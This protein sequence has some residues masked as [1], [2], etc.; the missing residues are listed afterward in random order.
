MDS[1]ETSIV[2]IS[3]DALNELF[4]ETPDKTVNADTLI[5]GKKDAKKAQQS[6]PPDNGDDDDEEDIEDDEVPAKKVD[7]NKTKKA[8]KVPTRQDHIETFTDEDLND[9]EEELEDDDEDK[10]P[11]DDEDEDKK[12]DKSK[13]GTKRAQ[14]AEDE[15]NDDENKGSDV[16]SILKSTVDYLVKQGVW[17]DFDGRE[18]MDIDEETYAKLVLEQDRHRVQ[19][20]FE[21][22]VDSTGPFG[23][24]IIDFV[25]NGGNPDEIIDLFKEQKQVE[26]INIENIDGQKDL[27]KHY[28]TDVMGWKP[29]KAE[30][31]ITSL[32]VSNELESEAQDVKEL[33]SNYYKK[34][35]ERLNQERADFARQQKEAEQAFENNIR[36]AVKERKDL[37]PSERRMVEDYLLN[38]DQRLPNGN[39]VN[40]FYV[41]F[42]KMQ[43]NPADYIDLVLFVMDKQKFVQKVATTEKSKA[44]AEAFK[45]IKGNSATSTKKGSGYEQIKK[46]EKVSGFDWGLPNNR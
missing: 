22:L 12:D 44:A 37:T 1:L 11:E 28:Y 45:F 9:D 39:T 16:S 42:A 23:K 30:K 3:E 17:D 4:D 10:K 19:G 15:G 13:K 29:E 40:K 35:A 6:T 21:E 32:V 38:Y 41:N 8:P 14:Q 43:A 2:D 5:G 7:K 46:N 27:I 24:A 26:S 18:D 31:Y 34:E 36:S 33:Y 25:K 20:M